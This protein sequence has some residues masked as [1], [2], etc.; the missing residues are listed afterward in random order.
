MTRKQTAGQNHGRELWVPPSEE[1]EGRVAGDM[2]SEVPSQIVTFWPHRNLRP[3]T[4]AY[5]PFRPLVTH[6]EACVG[7]E[8]TA[9]KSVED[10][11]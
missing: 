11:D 2:C 7:L 10:P 5:S 1:E 4:P 6:E 3:S 8:G 9:R